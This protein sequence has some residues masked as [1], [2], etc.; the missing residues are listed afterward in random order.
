MLLVSWH[1]FKKL[2]GL[3]TQLITK[4][5]EIQS[6]T[7]EKT[8]ES[9][10]LWKYNVLEQNTGTEDA[11]TNLL[12]V[13]G[14]EELKWNSS[15]NQISKTHKVNKSM[16]NKMFFYTFLSKELWAWGTPG[17]TALNTPWTDERLLSWSVPQWVV[18]FLECWQQAH[19]NHTRF[20][21]TEIPLGKTAAVRKPAWN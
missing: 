17:E 21:Y 19:F 8:E 7:A 14:A 12:D 3:A 9:W 13:Q 6:P 10:D 1:F 20:C 16:K 2:W 4:R 11:R 5:K 18:F 15:Q